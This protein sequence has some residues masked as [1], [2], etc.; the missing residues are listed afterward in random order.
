V[1]F[2]ELSFPGVLHADLKTRKDTVYQEL[3]LE[4]EDAWSLAP[5]SM[6]ERFKKLSGTNFIAYRGLIFELYILRTLIKSGFQVTYE[7]TA[8]ENM[9][10]IDFMVE[11][12]AVKF[13]VEVTTLGPNEEGIRNPSFDIVSE[14]YLN[15]RRALKNKLKKVVE[16]PVLPTILALCNS[17]ESFLSTSFEKVQVL[18]GVPAV[19]FN[20]E[21][22]ESTL[23][24]A[25]KGIWSEDPVSTQGYSA[26]YFNRGKY[27]GFSFLGRPEIWI[28]PSGKM[29]LELGLWPE[30]VTYFKSGESLHRTSRDQNFEW[31]TV[32]SIFD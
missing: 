26:A 23:M 24:F 16:P 13:L 8:L 10:S 4:I 22:A 14:G 31:T 25:D 1:K 11:K 9:G 17:H 3:R 32:K 2:V 7:Y 5:D 20:P 28:N 18:Y 19:R 12:D 21:T 27:P 30:D 6:Q 15:V 29:E